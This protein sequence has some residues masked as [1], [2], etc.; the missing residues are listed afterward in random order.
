[1]S[2]PTIVYAIHNF[3]AENEDEINFSVGEPITV[4]EKDEKY[5]DGW[6]QGKNM[7]GD[8]GL[9]P[10]NYTS[11]EKP[12]QLLPDTNDLLPIYTKSPHLS[13]QSSHSTLED[14]IEDTLTQIQ[15]PRTPDR[16]SNTIKKPEHWDMD[17]VAEW[18]NS[19]G[20]G[21]VASNF[22]D[23]EITGDILLD[24]NVD[25]LKELGIA[26]FGKRYKIMQAIH[27][28][29]E[30][31]H[32]A[33]DALPMPNSSVST[34]AIST[35]KSNSLR[36]SNSQSSQPN[37]EVLYQYPRKA[38]LPPV[39]NNTE[40]DYLHLL[41]PSHRPLSP[42][43]LPSSNVSRSN[44]FNTIS[45]SNTFRSRELSPD[46]KG[47]HSPR[48]VLSQKSQQKEE[49]NEWPVEINHHLNP[50]PQSSMSTPKE[51]LQMAQPHKLSID[52]QNIRASTTDAF[53]APEHEGWL[54]KQSD[55][56]KTWNKRWFVLK[57][58]NL[59]YFKSPKDVRMKGIINLRGYRIIVDE[60]IHAG[61][62]C[63]KAQHDKERTFFFYTDTEDSMRLWLKML[64]KTTIA[65]DFRA[66]VMSSNHVT[67]VSL[68]VAR[69]MRPR[70]PS[71]IMYKNQ[72][73]LKMNDP[74][75][76]MLQELE[77]TGT[78]VDKKERQTRESG[79]IVHPAPQDNSA[80]S[81]P[82]QSYFMLNEEEDLID[83]QHRS[84]PLDHSPSKRSDGSGEWNTPHY[85]DWINSYL[86]PGK[87]V[88]DLTSAFRNGDTLILLLEAIS[89]KEVRRP[90]AQKGGS[91]S[92][93]MLD[94]IV[95]AF[96]FMG[97]DGVDVDGR[98]TIKDV[99]GGNELKIVTMLE[100]IKAWAD[101]KYPLKQNAAKWS[102]E[103]PDEY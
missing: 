47:F 93:M 72:K 29:K 56:Y 21:S 31:L 15:L 98:Y 51:S 75:M 71:V 54:H 94:N 32:I 76:S 81:M 91:M 95:A 89:G 74:K 85:I 27:S 33:V 8:M 65:R 70:P 69:R 40:H 78:F 103:H 90:P 44:T 102:P 57:G 82:K 11:T 30:E 34:G 52:E 84:L 2:G 61:K 79:I 64:M 36:R 24:L 3:E 67:T 101:E 83:P 68:D 86:P 96:K 25:T 92:V 49:K 55:R 22:I 6:W 12:S 77:E 5:L 53:Q 16:S 59:F 18:L 60:T 97:R 62:Y 1:M 35:R 26:T 48:R 50:S 4:L 100:A 66:P 58:S 41:S 37:D 43:S 7:K 38:P 39:N 88:I 42:Q 9:F 10:M 23:Q 13:L 45:S 20:L 19:V 28:L 17:Q 73:P 46:S 63:F 87:K 14:E 80:P 99:F